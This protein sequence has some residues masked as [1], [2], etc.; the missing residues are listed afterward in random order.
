MTDQ[1][2]GGDDRNDDMDERVHQASP[3]EPEAGVRAE[4]EGDRQRTAESTGSDD[5]PEP[6]RARDDQDA[7]KRIERMQQ[8]GKG[9]GGKSTQ[10]RTDSADDE[11]IRRATSGQGEESP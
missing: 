10:G 2:P 5:A 1:R 8:E 7:T 4:S 6:V 11:A 9:M 3:G